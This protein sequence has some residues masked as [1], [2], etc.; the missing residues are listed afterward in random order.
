MIRTPVPEPGKV[1]DR[2]G[3]ARGRSVARCACVLLVSVSVLLICSGMPVMI[4]PFSNI[5]KIKLSQHPGHSLPYH[6]V[7]AYHFS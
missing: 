6:I 5:P 2:D 7:V 4:L 3:I 1:L